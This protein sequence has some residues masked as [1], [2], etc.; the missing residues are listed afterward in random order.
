MTNAQKTQKYSSLMKQESH[1]LII[2]VKGNEKC[3][4]FCYHRA[5]IP[6]ECAMR[7]CELR[8]PQGLWE[9]EVRGTRLKKL[10]QRH[11]RRQ[12]VI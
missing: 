8:K 9:N 3:G 1:T 5:Y 6:L 4:Q 11:M 12:A 10:H 7:N 2:I